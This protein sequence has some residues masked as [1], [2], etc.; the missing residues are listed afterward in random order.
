MHPDRDANDSGSDPQSVGHQIS[1]P[2]DVEPPDKWKIQFYYT[3]ISNI[4]TEKMNQYSL[5]SNET[6]EGRECSMRTV[7]KPFP[8]EMGMEP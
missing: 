3:R 1:F 7:L 4:Y 8:A 5:A 6:S 2:W